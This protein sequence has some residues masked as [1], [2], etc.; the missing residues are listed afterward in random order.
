MSMENTTTRKT[1]SL[2]RATTAL[3]VL[4]SLYGAGECAWAQSA[5]AAGDAASLLA[6]ARTERAA[7]HRIDA[8]A[9]CQQVL[10]RWP[11]NQDALQLN[12]QLLA[13]LGASARADELSSV[14][15]DRTARLNI[16]ADYYAHEVRWAR[17]EP[18]DPHQPYEAADQAAADIARL[19]NDPNTPADLR[20]RAQMDLL[21]VLD[22]ADRAGEVLA[23]YEPMKKQGVQL[24]PYAEQAVADAMMQKHRPAEAVALYEDS[25]RR[26]PG[27]YDP[28]QVDPRLGLASAYLA[29]GR[30]HDALKTIDALAASEPRWL[31][32]RNI[33]GN[34]QN[35][36]KVDADTSAAS[37]HQNV[38]L[39][40]QAHQQLAAMSAEAPG[41]ADIRRELAMAEL[42]RGWPRRALD[43]LKIADTVDER[44]AN[45]ALDQAEAHRALYDYAAAQADLAQAQ[46]EAGRSGR[47][48]DAEAEWQR[49]TGWQFDLT[50]DNG[51]GNSPDYGDRDQETQ[52]SIA[53]PLLDD[54]WR[55]V[56][57]AQ[58]ATAGLPEGDVARERAGLG[59]MGYFHAIEFYL[60]ALPSADS[61]VHRTAVEAG[62]TWAI[63]D[64]W[65]W[66]TDWS[67]AGN[68]IP[69]R[70]QYY[71]ITGNT[72]SNA[73][74]WRMSELT[75]ARVSVYRDRFSDG[76]LREGWLADFTQRLHTGPNL[77]WDGGVE[78]SGSHNSESDRPYFNPSEDRSYALT[79]TL[80]NV[81]SQYDQRSWSERFD[82]AVGQYAE[83]N[84]A[85]GLMLSARYGQIFQPKAGLRFGW[86]L[87]WHYQPYDG[88]HESR[89]VLD[90]SMHWGE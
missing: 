53:S 57:L 44:D 2:R 4:L 64:Q 26:D 10:A 40:Q 77:S 72:F 43:T 70:A 38:E 37:I 66:S 90:V 33:R 12:V 86:G 54:H 78:I 68:D 51:R 49:A 82:L 19:A 67:S 84:Y 42:A 23:L 83:R 36:R 45:A 13:E 9:H 5:P 32:Q 46:Q 88:R 59:V 3:C 85:T 75:S 35:P 24:P 74:Q 79:S 30:T 47:V 41:N 22:Q 1:P 34:T 14:L 87:G 89:L 6:L 61:F 50:H 71:G 16:R 31:H 60:R 8:L 76:N 80:Q 28:S 56:A 52:L 48:Q 58:Y 39:L 11:D 29:A 17:G 18:A 81:L 25:I 20:L 73:V 27:P 63:S 21:A 62:F 69:L 7:G 55:V 15:P 65:S